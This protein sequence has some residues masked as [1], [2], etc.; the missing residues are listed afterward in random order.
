[1]SIRDLKITPQQI[2]E[3]GVIASPDTLTGT[4]DENKSVF[5]RLASEIIVPSVNGAIEMLGDVEDDTTE[6]AA[7]EAQRQANETARQ[8][9][10]QGRVQAENGRASAETARAQAENARV[11]AEQ[12]RASAETARVQAE[13]GRASAETGRVS[14]EQGRVSAESG[15]VTAEQQRAAAEDDRE[16]AEDAR[17]L[18]EQQRADETAGIVAQA[19]AQA[20]AAEDSATLARSWAEGGTGTRS[21]EDTD[22]AAYY[23]GQAGTAAA[24]AL[25]DAQNAGNSAGAASDSADAAAASALAASQDAG[26]ALDSKDAAE[27][28]ADRA[29]QAAADAEAIA[30]GD[31][32]PS[33]QKGVANGVATLDS[34]GK[35]VMAQLPDDTEA[36]PVTLTAAGWSSVAPYTQTV[37]A[38]GVLAD[39]DAQMIIPVP[40]DDSSD[41]YY[42][43]GVRCTAQAAN[44]LT[45]TCDA[46][47]DDD[48]ALYAIVS[49]VGNTAGGGGT[50]GPVLPTPT[51]GDAGKVPTVNDA[52]DGYELKTP[53]GGGGTGGTVSVEVASTT[54]GDPGTDASVTNSGT[55]TDVKLN[56]TIPRGAT[57]ATGA[58]PNLQIG[59][60]TTL[61]A[62]SDATASITGTA[63]NPLLNLGIPKGADGG[64]G[65]GGISDAVNGTDDS[66]LEFKLTFGRNTTQDLTATIEYDEQD[67]TLDSIVQNGKS[68][69]DLFETPNVIPDGDFESD[70][71]W[72]TINAGDPQITAEAYSSPGHSLKCF[73]TTSQQ[74]RKAL[75]LSASESYYIAARVRLDRYVS[76][77][78]IGLQ[79]PTSNN[80]VTNQ[81]TNGQFVTVSSVETLGSG[82]AMYVGSISSANLDGYVDDIVIVPVS[83]FK[84]TDKSEIDVLYENYIKIKR[85][86]S[87]TP[88]P[89]TL[90]L[91]TQKTKKSYTATE[92]IA[93][94]MEAVTSKAADLGMANSTFTRPAGDG[95]NTTT[96]RDL[97]RMV[98][99]ASGY[100]DIARIWGKNSRDISVMGPNPRTVNV[101]TTVIDSELEASYH[102]FGGKTGSW[103]GTENLVV[104]A[105]TTKH[106]MVAGVIM[107]ATSSAARFDAMKELLD[108]V[109][110]TGSTVSSATAAIACAIPEYNVFN[111]EGYVFDALYELNADEEIIPASTTKVI[112]AM[113][114]LDYVTDIHNTI[115]FISSDAIGGSGAVFQTG[116]IIT[117]EDALCAMLLPSS[118]M[119]AQAL[120]RTVGYNML[121]KEESA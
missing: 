96:A 107:D 60:V 61:D 117:I 92:C 40:E 18:A 101:S 89:E 62:G 34:N 87:V 8:T 86:E 51:T 79:C 106:G 97:M 119:T 30:G 112:T 84:S 29:E 66:G 45:F 31:F 93:K 14:A 17:E 74:I 41:A 13:Q 42:R 50:S 104:A 57:G 2:A 65:T 81:L 102:I 76:G 33:S 5:D 4:P 35:L 63:E 58:T 91:E 114:A 94:F 44:S 109:D 83:N 103:S 10:E 21:G 78:G 55:N 3:K 37:P 6:W 99:E 19:T 75:G 52:E 71:S 69:R 15:R 53:S 11:S 12:G 68:Y 32:I 9:A 100:K 24:A 88:P 77:A 46:K 49:S 56:F 80:I 27:S 48:I 120:A 105:Q 26:S 95:G 20:E 110:G 72:A 54:T 67:L 25:Q 70:L 90:V 111:Y 118:N 113:V 64:G 22:N 115:E 116:D 16:D 73:G 36:I 108:V 59:E 23:A 43:A 47:P 28:A 121:V 82:S 7:D 85:G 98:V 38:N 39:E 1:M